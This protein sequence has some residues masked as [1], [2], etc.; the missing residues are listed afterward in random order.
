M[1]NTGKSINGSRPS[2]FANLNLIEVQSSND[3]NLSNIGCDNTYGQLI[4]DGEVVFDDTPK[5]KREKFNLR[6]SRSRFKQKI[7]QNNK[8]S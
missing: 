2:G 4:K 6:K 5:N 3:T 7:V 8:R 1:I